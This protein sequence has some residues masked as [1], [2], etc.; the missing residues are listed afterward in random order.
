MGM[1]TK[2]KIGMA[3]CIDACI[4][5]Y[6]DQTYMPFVAK[7]ADSGT[8]APLKVQATFD[9]RVSLQTG[10]YAD[11]VD[12]FVD[13]CLLKPWN[14]PSRRPPE[15]KLAY[16]DPKFRPTRLLQVA[17]RILT[18]DWGHFD[19]ATW[20]MVWHRL[21]TGRWI[22]MGNLPP[23]LSGYLQTN[24]ACERWLPP[25][26]YQT[27]KHLFGAVTLAG[28]NLPTVYGS[29]KA[30]ERRLPSTRPAQSTLYWLHYGDTD[31]LGHIYPFDSPELNRAL[32]EIDDSIRRWVERVQPDFIVIY[33]DHGMQP[34]IQT[35]DLWSELTRLPWQ[36]GYDYLVCLNSPMARFWCADDDVKTGLTEMLAN[37][38]V[39]GRIVTPKQREQARLP[40]HPKYG[41]IVFWANPGVNFT[42][43]FYH[44]HTLVGMH[45]FFDRE[46]PTVLAVYPKVPFAREPELVDLAP[47]IASLCSVDF[48]GADGRSL[49]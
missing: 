31:K 33:G 17:N 34:V 14:R 19:E 4:G 20:A 49:I 27:R 39:I 24:P 30:I 18:G 1:N 44:R 46:V 2:T 13:L 29:V 41:E 8:L 16:R 42:P 23:A 3:I 48:Q 38:N 12:S 43:D 7:L 25:A 36:V 9:A 45:G 11:T 22:E 21:R 40:I 35:V 5:E 26:A 37:L 28:W 10:R 6:V 15:I 47:T 32:R